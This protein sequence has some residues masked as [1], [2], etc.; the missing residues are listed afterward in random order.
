MP[1]QRFEDVIRVGMGGAKIPRNI[2]QELR[3]SFT[4][5]APHGRR[6]PHR[7]RGRRT[8]QRF[9]MWGILGIIFALVFFVVLNIFEKATLKIIPKQEVVTLDSLLMAQK[10]EVDKSNFLSFD[11]M[12]DRESISRKVQAT[13]VKHVERRAS[14][15]IVIYNEFNSRP[16]R[17]IK[18]TRFETTDGKIYRIHESVIVP[19]QQIVDDET[20]PGS[21]EVRVFADETGEA[22]NIGLVDFIIPGFK[23]TPRFEDF[24]ARSNTPMEGGFIGVVKAISDGEF[25][26][27]IS[28]LEKTLRQ[29]LLARALSLVP[30]DFILYDDAI[31]F[32]FEEE[33]SPEQQD[34]DKDSVELT[35][36]AVL[37]AIIFRRDVLSNYIAEKLITDFRENGQV[38][39]PNLHELEFKISD[40]ENFDPENDTLLSFSLKGM[41]KIT[42]QFDE[43]Q[44][45]TML[46]GLPKNSLTD[47]L[48]QFA[49]IVRAE[50]VLRPFWK[51][52]FPK[53]AEDI[54]IEQIIE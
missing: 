43:E 6:E 54:K 8:H 32:E 37:R 47:V 13:E 5:S 4:K 26:N 48:V 29:D 22:Y 31:F 38:M 23:G 53:N 51:R 40:K 28:E 15:K 41:P 21:I 33:G 25:E 36:E 2:P 35:R 45:R 34:I 27:L 24:Y 3:A 17:L 9:L 1:R 42:W 11:I 12:M 39:I 19:G 52:S 50:V 30:Q 18:N 20:V 44:L 14:G 16:Q 46:V 7:L 10:G 49:S